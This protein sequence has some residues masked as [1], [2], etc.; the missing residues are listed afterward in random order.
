MR[1]KFITFIVAGLLMI[2][3]A[4]CGEN[5]TSDNRGSDTNQDDRK[6]ED[7]IQDAVEEGKSD[8]NE[9]TENSS[10]EQSKDLT[11]ADLAKYSFEFCSGA[12]GWSTD[13]EI[14]K[15]GSFSGS[16]HDSEMGSTGDGYENG[17]MYICVFSGEFT[18]LTKI[19]DHTYQMKMKNL[20]CDGTPGTEE[21]IDGIKYISVSEVYGLEGTDTF[22]VYLPGTPVNDLSEEVYF[23]VQWANE[24]SGEGTQDTLTIPIIVNEEMKYGI[25]SFE[26]STPYEEARGIFTSCKVSYDAAS[27]ELKKATMQS[28]MDDYA[29]QMYDVSDSCL[30]K[31]WN[32]VKYNTSEEKFNEILAEQRKWIADKEAAGNEILEQN[33]GSSAQMDSCLIMAELTMERC[34]KLIG[35]LN[36]PM[37]CP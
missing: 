20:T 33:D 1:K 26:R 19:N 27:E 6:T 25:Y 15:D 18:E 2:S 32:L 29:M 12:G 7:T 4:A 36:E 9:S 11:F 34:E 8:G 31:I 23:W 3:L 30:N 14:E 28:R 35:Y 22:K 5:R 17:T 21:I 24:D 37:T 13:F 16:Y 10:D